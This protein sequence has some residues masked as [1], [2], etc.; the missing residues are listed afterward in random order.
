MIDR[1]SL[2]TKKI[3]LDPLYKERVLNRQEHLF[4]NSILSCILLLFF[5]SI[6]SLKTYILKEHS[7]TNIPP[8]FFIY[9]LIAFSIIFFLSRSGNYMFY[10]YI[11][12]A[13]SFLAISIG[14]YCWGYELSIIIIGYIILIFISTIIHGTKLGFLMTIYI[15]LTIIELGYFRSFNMIVPESYWKIEPFGFESSFEYAAIF[16]LVMVLAWLARKETEH[17]LARLKI[18]EQQLME[19][20][21]SLEIKIEERTH[22]LKQSQVEQ[23]TELYKFAEFGKLSSGFFHDLINCLSPLCIYIENFSIQPETSELNAYLQGA[24]A[25]SRKTEEFIDSIGKQIKMD[26]MLEYFYP[27]KEIKE[28]ILLLTYKAKNLNVSIHQKLD[29]TVLLYGNC[30]KF[31]QI[32]LNLISNAIDSYQDMLRKDNRTVWVVLKKET[33]IILEIIDHGCGIHKDVLP[34]IFES[35]FTTKKHRKGMGIGLSITKLITEKDFKGSIETELAD[36]TIFRVKIPL[37]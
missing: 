36:S 10:S 31:N 28:V 21:D 34:H 29:E 20:R 25:T 33:E 22:L 15:S 37:V 32:V 27:V 35:F 24:I 14:A 7:F 12:I 4:N 19:E 26:D 30:L 5:L 2:L 6:S 1:L 16:I 23:M 17:S 8:S 9:L 3:L 11:S 18:S 13:L